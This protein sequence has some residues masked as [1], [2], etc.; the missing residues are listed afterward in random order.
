LK[1]PILALREVPGTLDRRKALFETTK[2]ECSCKLCKDPTE[3]G[4]YMSAMRCLKCK[5]K[6]TDEFKSEEEGNLGYLLPIDPLNENSRWKCNKCS[7]ELAPQTLLETVEDSKSEFHDIVNRYTELVAA[8]IKRAYYIIDTAITCNGNPTAEELATVEM[9]VNVIPERILPDLEQLMMSYRE[10]LHRNHFIIIWILQ[11]YLD[12]LYFYMGLNRSQ[13]FAPSIVNLR[14]VY[15]F[16]FKETHR[17]W[18]ATTERWQQLNEDLYSKAEKL[19]KIFKRVYPD[20][21]LSS[22]R[23]FFYL[24]FSKWREEFAENPQD[25][26]GDEKF[27]ADLKE[28]SNL[29]LKADNCFRNNSLLLFSQG[30]G[31]G[32]GFVETLEKMD[33][34]DPNIKKDAFANVLLKMSALDPNSK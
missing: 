32:G 34:Y 12:F 21:S 22:G 7:G 5:P 10:H 13:R 4:S 29:K 9:E 28:W 19:I 26:E 6:L 33:P 16:P 8:V 3:F 27:L 17:F 18:T 1:L 15:G 31:S 24:T 2:I 30:A 23:V 25:H 14:Q 11:A 20:R